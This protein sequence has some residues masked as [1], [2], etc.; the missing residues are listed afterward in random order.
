MLLSAIR[1]NVTDLSNEWHKRK[2]ALVCFKMIG[3]NVNSVPLEC[4]ITSV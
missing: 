3:Q 4:F 1:K 2:L